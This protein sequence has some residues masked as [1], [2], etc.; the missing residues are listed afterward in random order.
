MKSILTLFWQICLLRQSPATV[1]TPGALVALVVVANVACSTLLALGLYTEGTVTQT[2]AGILV[3][4]ATMAALVMLALSAKNL[5][6]RF[7]TTV[8]ALFGCDLIITAGAGLLLPLSSMLG[9][10]AVNVVFLMFLVWSVAVTGFIMHRALQVQL[11]IGIGI[12][13]AISLM[14]ATMSRLAAGA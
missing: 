12:G 2:L 9:Q 7:V 8:T 3:G 14:S 6:D 1:P 13:M 5:G 10:T 11:A 4:Q